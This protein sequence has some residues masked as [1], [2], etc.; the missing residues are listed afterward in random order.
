[1]VSFFRGVCRREVLFRVVPA[2]SISFL[3]RAFS[4]SSISALLEMSK[5]CLLLSS[6]CRFVSSLRSLCHDTVHGGSFLLRG[7]NAI[8][9]RFFLLS[10]LPVSYGHNASPS[11]HGKT[12]LR[13]FWLHNPKTSSLNGP[14]DCIVTTWLKLISVSIQ[15]ICTVHST[16]HSTLSRQP[17]R[18]THPRLSS[19]SHLRADLSPPMSHQD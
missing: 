12:R 15:S 1:V 18:E 4:S 11:R 7:G 13:S 8:A 3:S 6:P 17:H 2:Q 5:F 14:C 9:E 10:V 19:P 16:I